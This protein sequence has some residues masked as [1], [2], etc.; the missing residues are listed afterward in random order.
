MPQCC[1]GDA[2][3]LSPPPSQQADYWRVTP[4]LLQCNIFWKWY[5]WALNHIKRGNSSA[6]ISG[7]KPCPPFL[8]SSF[9]YYYYLMWISSFAMHSS[10]PVTQNSFSVCFTYSFLAMLCPTQKVTEFI[11]E[12]PCRGSSV[13]SSFFSLPQ[14][15]D[16]HFLCTAAFFLWKE[17][18]FSTERNILLV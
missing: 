10:F 13:S 18:F 9:H 2:A 5:S 4:L 17:T 14:P 3:D 16:L 6:A 1:G 7:Y 15:E 8:Q 11:S 12:R